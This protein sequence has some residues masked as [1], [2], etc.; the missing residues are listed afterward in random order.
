M[1]KQKQFIGSWKIAA[2][3]AL[4]VGLLSACIP[5]VN[6]FYSDKDVV[7]DPRLIGE[8]QPQED[9]KDTET[10]KFEP[11]EAKAYKLT[12][13]E[14][15]G[16]QGE[17]T[18]HLFKLKQQLFLDLI[19]TEC[20]YATNEASLVA[21]SMIP[22]HL[23][24]RVTQ[25]EP[26][27]KLALFDFDWLEKHLKANPKTLAHRAAGDTLVLTASTRD[28]QRFVLKHLGEDELF[29]SPSVMTRKTGG[30]TGP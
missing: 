10:W 5:S 14:E 30:P 17:F 7:H 20:K 25:I 22:G 9:S 2:T 29:E 23:L 21:A 26:E 11:A 1:K 19:P 12:V 3:V 6:P 16:R 8:W 15:E 24:V 13:T 18:A 27:L 28:L 4:A